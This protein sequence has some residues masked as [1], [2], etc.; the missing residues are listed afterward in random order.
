MMTVKPALVGLVLYCSS[1]LCGSYSVSTGIDYKSEYHNDSLSKESYSMHTGQLQAENELQNLNSKLLPLIV[2]LRDKKAEQEDLDRIVAIIANIKKN[3]ESGVVESLDKSD[4]FYLIGTYYLLTNNFTT[5]LSFF[6]NSIAIREKLKISDLRL[7]RAVYNMGKTYRELGNFHNSVE[8]Q[9]KAL[10]IFIS[11]L[12][13][14]SLELIDP[15]L[16]MSSS[17]IELQQHESAVTC[18]NTAMAIAQNKTDSISPLTIANL[19][20]NLGVSNSKLTDFVKARIYYE[21]TLTIYNDLHISTGINYVNLIN[22]LA[23]TYKSLGLLDKSVEY[24]EKGVVLALDMSENSTYSFNIVNNYAGTLAKNGDIV[25]GEELIKM[26][27]KKASVDSVKMSQLY[28]QTL[29]NYAEFLREYKKDFKKSMFYFSKCMDYMNR[30]PNDLLLKLNINT[31]YALSLAQSG[32]YKKAIAIIQSLISSSY[33]IEEAKEDLT[34]PDIES[35]NP[36][37]GSLK[38]FRTKHLLLTRLY[39]RSNDIKYL[40]ASAATAELIVEL[41]EK[42]RINISEEDSRLILGDRYRDAYF[43]AIGD[44]H[45]LYTESSDNKY[46]EKVFEFSEKSKVAGLLTST[47]ELKAIQF[48]IPSDIADYE[49]RLK[50]EI[51]LLHSKINEESFREKLD[52]RVIK[53]LSENLLKSIRLRDSLILVFE[54][55]FPEYY[56]IK[57][58]AGVVEMNDIHHIV[59]ING[60][61][62]SYT[63]SDT[64]LYTF[65]ANRKFKQIIATEVKPG[66]FESIEKYRNL[67]SKPEPSEDALTS[68][69]QYSDIGIALYKILIEPVLPY[70]ISERLIIS[71]DNLLSYIPFETLPSGKGSGSKQLYRSLPYLMDNFD[72]SY[73]YSVT[74]MAE[75]FREGYRFKNKVMAFAPDYPVNIDIQSVFLSRQAQ[76]GVLHD[77]PYARLEAKY[78]TDL[79]GGKLYE[80]S[81]ASESTFKKESGNYNILHLA[82]HTLLNDKDPMNSALIFSAGTDTLDDRF[83]K[84]YEI[85]GM[86]LKAKMVVLSSCNTGSGILYSGEGILS[87]ARGFIYSGSQSVVMSMWEIEDRSGTEIVKMFYDNLKKGYSKSG[88]LRKARTNYLKNSDQLRSHPYF[89]STLVVYGNNDP[90]YHNRSLILAAAILSSVILLTV[91]VY[92]RRRR[93]S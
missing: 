69:Q 65:V 67:L 63:M 55:N 25:K 74:F 60:N 10:N 14:E 49:F 19:F 31:G 36:D 77:L 7:G 11:L 68:F 41:L 75:N 46:L 17:Y 84:T 3:T 52:N 4:S 23:S 1:I 42:M 78:V 71:P 64:V 59:G 5:A 35:I 34:N 89:W 27:I 58:N 86:P 2:L 32:E 38:L 40:E 62:I 88:A 13:D 37:L 90:L 20:N 66:F 82:M 8:S 15:Y 22:S 51:G 33:K 12:G 61:Y 93:Y 57:Y 39:K 43:S 9:K 47:R 92:Q 79:T 45:T 21:R 73:T 56:A 85:Y 44:Y 53:T 29:Y 76:S 70:I 80:N 54:H 28:N 87:L 18:L 81:D 30:N 16:S 6:Q 48:R 26:L 83:L 50:N 24:Y 72:I 91:V